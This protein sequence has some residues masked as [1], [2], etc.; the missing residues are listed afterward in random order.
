MK[1]DFFSQFRAL[2]YLILQQNVNNWQFDL[3][4]IP[5]I[6]KVFLFFRKLYISPD[7]ILIPSSTT[8]SGKPIIAHN[9][10]CRIKNDVTW[11][12]K[13]IRRSPPIQPTTSYA[14]GITMSSTF[15][16]WPDFLKFQQ[17]KIFS[18]EF[19]IADSKHQPLEYSNSNSLTPYFRIDY[20]SQLF[21]KLPHLAQKTKKTLYQL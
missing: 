10:H 1:E 12:K 20:I 3:Y 17:L 4:P 19:Y 6:Y 2:L 18:K 14:K 16:P 15:C 9:A 11:G 8:T 21:H 5:F 7:C 13:E